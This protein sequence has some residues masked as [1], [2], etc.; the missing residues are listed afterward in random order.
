M[1]N[2]I[3]K[4]LVECSDKGLPEP[5]QRPP[6]TECGPETKNGWLDDVSNVKIGLGVG[7]QGDPMQT[8]QILNETDEP[9]RT[10]VYRYSKAVRACD[11]AM[12][13]MFRNVVVIDEDGK[14]YPVPIV[15]GTQEK[16]VAAITFDNVRKDNSLVVDRIRLPIMAIFN[17]SLSFNQDR[18]VYHKAVDYL[19]RYRSDSKPGFTV[20]EKYE[21]DTIFGMARGIP[22]DIGYTLYLWT[23]Y[24]EDMNQLVEQVVTKFSPIAYI[25][26]RGI[27]WETGVKLE[28]IANNIDLEPGDQAIRVIK[29]EFNFTVEAYI[30]QPIVRQK[31]V[32][33]TKVDFVNDI[34][35]KN[36]DD[37]LT[38]M[39]ESVEEL[40]GSF[41]D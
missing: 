38:R 26:A 29:Y 41:N 37:I 17:N 39:E 7:Q 8:G 6:Q 31:A 9:D 40:K 20:K 14:A 12:Q 33:N 5:I 22:I 25:Q 13:D 11:E 28:S 21:R 15:W 3:P 23:L 10:H 32:L 1:R 30:P 35:E 18:Y 4:S 24:L 27:P 16:A 19:R 36:I 34:D 2:N